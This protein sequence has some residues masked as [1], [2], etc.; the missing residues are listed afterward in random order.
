MKKLKESEEFN[1]KAIEIYESLYQYKNHP[2]LA[3][4]YGNLA[5]TYFYSNK[6]DA[7]EAFFLKAIEIYEKL[8]SFKNH[9]DLA[10][11]YSN[12][13]E[14]YHQMNKFVEI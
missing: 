8:Y 11:V 2:D 1:L 3:G 6:L 5:N 10:I 12:L 13:A 9:L 7:S 4:S 14:T